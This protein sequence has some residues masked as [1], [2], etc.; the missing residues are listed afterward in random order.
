MQLYVCFYNFEVQYQANLQM[1]RDYETMSNISLPSQ[2]LIVR[3]Y[4]QNSIACSLQLANI[5]KVLNS[6]ALEQRE[7]VDADMRN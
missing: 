5:K 1:S 4:K 3:I 2:Q 6:V 7:K